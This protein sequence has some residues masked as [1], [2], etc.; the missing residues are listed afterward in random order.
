MSCA[1][2]DNILNH[3]TIDGCRKK[4]K[5]D[6]KEASNLLIPDTKI[7]CPKR[8]YTFFPSAHSSQGRAHS[9]LF[10]DIKLLHKC[11]SNEV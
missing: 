8:L 10:L 2:L 11:R 3:Q 1:P 5:N 7:S 6:V 4:F 9:Q